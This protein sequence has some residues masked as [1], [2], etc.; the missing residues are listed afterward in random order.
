MLTTSGV[1]EVKFRKEHFAIFDKQI[2]KR[3]PD[4]SKKVI[5]RSWFNRGNLLIIQGI[6]NGDS[7][8]A[9]KYAST[10]GH[11]LYKITEVK[12]NGDLGLKDEREKGDE[13][14]G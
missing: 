8:T 7:F 10:P 1:V 14:N 3:Q 12:S 4:G 6:R 9:K 13:D 5:E 2:S 11:T